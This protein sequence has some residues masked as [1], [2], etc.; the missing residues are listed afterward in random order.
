[1][2]CAA[3]SGEGIT[4]AAGGRR[5][6]TIVDDVPESAGRA[7][8][9][10]LDCD[11]APNAGWNTDG[12]VLHQD[13]PVIEGRGKHTMILG[14]DR[15]AN[16]LIDA[17][18]AISG[19]KVLLHDTTN[20]ASVLEGTSGPDGKIEFIG[21]EKIDY[22]VE[23]RAPWVF[24][25]DGPQFVRAAD[26]GGSSS[27][28]LKPVP[29]A[30]VRATVTFS[31]PRFESH[32]TVQ[33]DLTL[34]N[35]GGESTGVWVQ[36]DSPD[37]DIPGEQWEHYWLR[38]TTLAPGE[39][40]TFTVAGKLRD[41]RNGK[42]IVSGSYGYSDQ[43][44]TPRKPFHAE[45]EIVQTR[46]AL[47]GFVHLD[48]NNNGQ[49]DP[50]E[51]AAGAVVEANGGAPYGYYKATT[52]AEGRYSF[53]DLPAGDYSV[54]Y[55]LAGSWIV[56][57]PDNVVQKVRVE[58]G[59]PVQLVAGAQRPYAEVLKA[60]VQFDKTSYAVG[61]EVKITVRLTNRGG[62]VINGVHALCNRDR[63][64]NN[65]GDHRFPADSWGDLRPSA[66]GVTVGPGETVTLVVTE[67][68]PYEARRLNRVELLCEFA[69]QAEFGRDFASAYDWAHVPGGGPGSANVLVAYDKDEDYVIDPGDAIGNVR[70]RLM[71]H[72]ENGFLVAE[73]TTDVWGWARFTG[74]PAGSY[75]AEVDGPWKFRNENESS[76][77]I[78]D[79]VAWPVLWMVPGPDPA[80]PGAGDQPAT[81]GTSNS[82]T[83]VALARTGA[84][85]L[86][87][88]FLGVLLLT[89]GTALRRWPRH[90]AL[91][92]TERVGVLSG[93]LADACGGS[94]V[95]RHDH[96][97]V[98]GGSVAG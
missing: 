23:V 82:G 24:A 66:K 47:T 74:V 67:V 84:G 59:R 12:P 78:S 15:N 4:L 26:H 70:V 21:L 43:P 56:H 10:T 91:S 17:D 68:V 36:G 18:E 44:H 7:G 73:A 88:A 83:K 22:R 94:D 64:T 52:D 38:S 39:S 3:L 51:A 50:G 76:V 6:L 34:T 5:A 63:L 65:L 90:S 46:G 57:V 92:E 30:D 49:P 69:P 1:M 40:R 72:R 53:S 19:A 48:K 80:Q 75:W 93:R 89:A 54:G 28:F 27:R 95:G 71:S 31:K 85:V 33:W 14:E 35:V 16:S 81:G 79:G 42:V 96:R 13:A 87:L 61:D 58:P 29:P 32:E 9:V 97:G 86:G 41:Y 62:Y 20:P 77:W 45:V 8:K 37:M 55:T 98:F 2:S 60:T 25:S 11:F